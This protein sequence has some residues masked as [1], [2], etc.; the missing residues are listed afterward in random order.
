MPQS[1][2][3][4]C[5]LIQC[6]ANSVRLYHAP[7]VGGDAL[8][9][10]PFPLH[11]KTVE[12]TVPYRSCRKSDLPVAGTGFSGKCKALLEL[13]AREIAD[14]PY[15]RGVRRPLAEHPAV[16]GSVQSVV[17]MR[18]RPVGQPLPSGKTL[19]QALHM[20]GTTL[21]GVTERLKPGIVKSGFY[22]FHGH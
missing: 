21:Y 19:R 2:P 16:G 17:F 8:S 9:P 14:K 20:G 4:D 11:L 15:R 22:L 10:S 13:P 18:G 3:L 5:V 6:C 12:L 7:R 1:S